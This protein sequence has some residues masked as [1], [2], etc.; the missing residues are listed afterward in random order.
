MRPRILFVSASRPSL[1]VAPN[2][3]GAAGY[4][5]SFGMPVAG[6]VALSIFDVAGRRV[7]TLLDGDRP[8]G[9]AR[10]RW[11]DRSA[12]GR[13]VGGGVYFARLD[14]AAGARTVKLVHLDR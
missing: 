3:G 11:D 7:A 13:P 8:P 12:Q 1:V 9:A 5:V 14:T 2:P 4:T 10:L 6:R